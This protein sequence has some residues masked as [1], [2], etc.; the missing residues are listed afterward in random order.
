[1]LTLAVRFWAILSVSRRVRFWADRSHLVKQGFLGL[2]LAREEVEIGQHGEVTRMCAPLTMRAS[3]R[4]SIALLIVAIAAGCSTKV[5]YDSAQGWQRLEC[6]KLQ[7][8][9]TRDKCLADTST[10]YEDFQRQSRN[11]QSP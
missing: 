2:D 7:D 6:Q 11:L 10:R 1:M 9:T 4:L 8:K 3:G 5:A